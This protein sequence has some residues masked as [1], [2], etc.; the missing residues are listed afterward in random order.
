MQFQSYISRTCGTWCLV[1]L[2]QHFSKQ[3]IFKIFNKVNKINNEKLLQ[4]TAY[5]LFPS[6]ICVYRRKCQKAKGQICKTYLEIFSKKNLKNK[7][8]FLGNYYY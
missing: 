4:N 2:Y 8:I 7:K 3:N 6:M 1:F 5:I